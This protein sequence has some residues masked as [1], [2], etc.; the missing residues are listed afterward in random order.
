MDKVQSCMQGTHMLYE[1]SKESLFTSSHL[2]GRVLAYQQDII[3]DSIMNTNCSY[4]ANTS[5]NVSVNL[6]A[7]L[8]KSIGVCK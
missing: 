6:A 3:L 5:A 4:L 8:A 7:S 2:E 1:T